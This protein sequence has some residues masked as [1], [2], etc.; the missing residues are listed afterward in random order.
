MNGDRLTLTAECHGD[1][2]LCNNQFWFS[3]QNYFLFYLGSL[4][5]WHRF[6]PWFVAN[7]LSNLSSFAYHLI[8]PV[9]LE[10]FS[11]LVLLKRM[12]KQHPFC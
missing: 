10:L 4:E 1:N 11:S 3:C 12:E 8:L 9:V 5:I 6:F 2:I 7:V